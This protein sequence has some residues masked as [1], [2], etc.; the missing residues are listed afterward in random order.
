MIYNFLTAGHQNVLHFL[1]VVE[2]LSSSAFMFFF[3]CF[4]F[5]K[6]C[7]KDS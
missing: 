7:A 5:L 6:I 3:N 1:A 4:F 2:E